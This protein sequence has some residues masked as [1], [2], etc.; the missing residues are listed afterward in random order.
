MCQ[1]ILNGSST[2]KT[3]LAWAKQRLSEIDHDLTRITQQEEESLH[4][5]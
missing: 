1:D 3:E 4:A 2:D 5:E